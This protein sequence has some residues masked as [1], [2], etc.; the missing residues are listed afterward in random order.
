MQR[1]W[2]I[3]LAQCCCCYQSGLPCHRRSFSKPAALRSARIS[4]IS[5]I[6]AVDGLT[7]LD[8]WFTSAPYQSAF[9]VTAF[10]AS[11][12]DLLTQT[13]EKMALASTTQG[14]NGNPQIG[15]NGTVLSCDEVSCVEVDVE[16]AAPPRGAFSWQRTF[17]FFL[18]GG[19][20]QGC[21]QYYIFNELYP[22]WFGEG[23]DLQTV[24]TKVCVDQFLLT[25][26]LCLPVAYLVK[27]VVFRYSLAE[28]LSRYVA[29]AKR[30]LLLKYWVLWGPVQ[31]LTFSVVPPQWR[32]PFIALVSFFWLII[33]STITAREAPPPAELEVVEL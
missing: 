31:C 24:A 2:L 8:T 18:Y 32:V 14:G 19:L 10:K 26:F 15:I 33:L 30:D 6:S 25:P 22:V 4:H 5:H 7:A 21:A 16:V 27:A 1:F 11:A 12:A 28:G 13:R 17:A 23:T 20:Y 9:A 29:D 3:A